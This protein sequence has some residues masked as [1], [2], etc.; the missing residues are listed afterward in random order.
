MLV[1]DTDHLTEFQKGTSPEAHALKKRLVDSADSYA[2][3]I[4]TVEEIMRGWMAA[5]R[6][7][8]HP[9]RQINPYARLRQLFRFFATWNVLEWDDRAADEFESLK[10]AKARIGS[11]D[12]KIAS[13]CLAHDATLLS[14]N[15]KDF[16]NVPQLRVEDWLS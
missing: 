12:L 7:I 8:H 16:D 1:L 9:R 14:R 5:I 6:R 10:R 13:I 11:M 2:T 3:T 4:I 15:R